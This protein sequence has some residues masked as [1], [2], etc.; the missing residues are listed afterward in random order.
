MFHV[1]LV[2][3]SQYQTQILDASWLRKV[4]NALVGGEFLPYKMPNIS[5]YLGKNTYNIY[6]YIIYIQYVDMLNIYDHLR[7]FKCILKWVGFT[8]LKID[9]TRIGKLK[10]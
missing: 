5:R 2:V 8:P 4:D 1:I 7:D 6:I 10:I 9:E 3:T